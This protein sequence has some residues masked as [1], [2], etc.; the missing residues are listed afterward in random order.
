MAKLRFSWN[1]NVSLL[2]YLR[3]IEYNVVETYTS[4]YFWRRR[5]KERK[6]ER[7]RE[8]REFTIPGAVRW[9]YL[10]DRQQ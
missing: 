2:L 3:N 6:R 8:E 5:E 1:N 10:T 9:M 4:L 7:E